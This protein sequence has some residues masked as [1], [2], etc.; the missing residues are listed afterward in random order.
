[1]ALPF[2]SLGFLDNQNSQPR[3]ECCQNIPAAAA[4]GHSA[5]ILCMCIVKRD[6]DCFIPN[7]SWIED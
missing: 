4:V 2:G 5:R 6:D 3:C 7:P 1:M